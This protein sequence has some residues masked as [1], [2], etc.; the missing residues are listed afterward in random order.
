M[1]SSAATTCAGAGEAFDMEIEQEGRARHAGTFKNP[2]VQ[3]A[4]PRRGPPVDA[5]HG[6]ALLIGTNAR[7]AGRVLEETM[8]HTNFPNR[9][10]RSQAVTLQRQHFGRNQHIMGVGQ[11]P[12]TAVQAKDIPGLQTQRAELI[13]AAHKKRHLVVQMDG[14]AG[15]E[16]HQGQ[17]RSLGLDALRNLQPGRRAARESSTNSQGIASRPWFWIST[18]ISAACADLQGLL[19][20][21]PRR[22]RC[23][24]SMRG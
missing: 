20:A 12:E 4:G 10:P 9:P 8:R 14:V 1:A 23:F 2:A 11:D 15:R 22:Q 17:A 18:V 21:E 16:P 7:D 6:V 19:A 5:V 24:P 13:I 3:H